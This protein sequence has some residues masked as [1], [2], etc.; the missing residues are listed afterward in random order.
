MGTIYGWNYQTGQVFNSRRLE[1]VDNREDLSLP[2]EGI[3]DTP[4]GSNNSDFIDRSG[5]RSQAER[6]YIYE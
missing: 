2:V 1:I 3:P 6:I 5:G 4:L